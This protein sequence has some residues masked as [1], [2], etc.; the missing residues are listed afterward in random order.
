MI[1]KIESDFQYSNQKTVKL[2]NRINKSCVESKVGRD[3]NLGIGSTNRRSRW[4]HRLWTAPVPLARRSSKAIG[5]II[6]WVLLTVIA[7][8]RKTF[9]DIT[10]FSVFKSNNRKNISSLLWQTE[11][12]FTFIRIVMAF[13]FAWLD[14]SKVVVAGVTRQNFLAQLTTINAY[15]FVD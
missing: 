11:L 6:G 2:R 3:I 10:V 8:I 15:L 14:M 5:T 4:L 7:N 12:V 9:A 13:L 1:W